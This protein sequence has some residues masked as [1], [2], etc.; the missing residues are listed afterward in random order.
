MTQM[1][2]LVD[3]EGDLVSSTAQGENLRAERTALAYDAAIHEIF[4]K[5]RIP[6]HDLGEVRKQ[7]DALDPRASKPLSSLQKTL[8]E[9]PSGSLP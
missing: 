5:A 9:R 6:A 4:K 1:A 3:A 2:V 7:A 8:C